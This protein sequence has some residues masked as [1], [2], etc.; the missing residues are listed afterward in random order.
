MKRR[1]FIGVLGGAVMVP[2]ALHAQV[3]PR[4][5]RIGILSS[6]SATDPQG[7]ALV[8]SLKAGLIEKGWTEGRNIEIAF[9]YAN[10][11]L[12]RLPTLAADLVQANV[13]IIITNGTPA[14]QALRKASATMPIVFATIGDPVG[15]GIAQPAA[16]VEMPLASLSR[17]DRQKA[18]WSCLKR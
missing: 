18:L 11:N 3:T 9:R 10:E 1:D 6:F 16:P 14:V 12:D 17:N 7:L 4:L 8:A 2:A 15:A 5:R 13:E